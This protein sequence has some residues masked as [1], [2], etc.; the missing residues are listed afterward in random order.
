[1]SASG[2]RQSQRVL[3]D[4]QVR[5]TLR[6][7]ART[8]PARALDLSEGGI[9]ISADASLRVGVVRLGDARMICMFNWDETPAT[10]SF[11]LQQP[12]TVTDFWTDAVLGRREGVVSIEMPARSARLLKLT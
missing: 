11:A 3:I 2:A 10:R 1:M 7:A 8:L 9:R 5:L 4:A 6:E 12:A